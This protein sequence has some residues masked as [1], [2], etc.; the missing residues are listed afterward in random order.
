VISGC[1]K[2]PVA[3][4]GPS[5][6]VTCQTWFAAPT[7]QLTAVFSPSTG[8]TMTGSASPPLSLMI[9]QD[10][11]STALD[12]SRTVGMGTSTTF[13]ATV[14]TTPGRLGTT[15]PTGR[16]EFFD[17]A[18]PIAS[19]PAQPMTHAGATCTVTYDSPGSH[20][21]S[22]QYAG[23]T[24][25]R[26]SAAAAQAMTVIKPPRRILG[27]ITSTMQWNFYFTPTYTKVLT[28]V[29]NGASGAT[30]TT[31]C[32]NTG[33][34]FAVKTAHVAK[35]GRCAQQDTRTCA[36]HGW[37]NLAPGFRGR[38]LGVGAQI[39]VAITRPGW[40][41]KSYRFTIHAGR[42]PRIQIA[43]LAAGSAHRGVGCSTGG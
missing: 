39:T 41:G 19:C 36:T 43:C 24:N 38:R 11:T 2:E 22:A 1:A 4:T 33:C 13:T 17:G 14:T 34:P 3:P 18:R 35:T 15:Q 9:G 27:L 31:T 23:D 30:V 25:F 37:L 40:I 16:V 8:A 7:A 20:S 10:A 6:V 21:I 26:G 29:V 42:P 12:V 32:H 5:V 28:L